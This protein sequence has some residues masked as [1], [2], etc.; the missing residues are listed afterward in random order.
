[1]N[2]L[3]TK[4]EIENY[5]LMAQNG[6]M[7]LFFKEWLVQPSE[8]A[9]SSNKISYM[10]ASKNVKSVFNDLS[11]HKTLSKM[12]TAIISMET[13]KRD[14][15]MISFLKMVEHKNLKESFLLQ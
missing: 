6:H 15:F 5:L 2:K 10:R 3:N 12:Q 14:E 9:I 11:R 1:M 13:E 8:K 4:H 7:P